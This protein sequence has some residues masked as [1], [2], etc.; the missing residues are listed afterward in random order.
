MFQSS[1]GLSTGCNAV[2]AVLLYLDH[3]V[4]ILTRSFD[5]M[6]RSYP[7]EWVQLRPTAVSILTRSF[8]RMQP[9]GNYAVTRLGYLPS[10]NPHP[11]FRPDA[12]G[13]LVQPGEY[14]P[15]AVSILIR[16]KDRVQH[17]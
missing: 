2:V 11:V 10:F 16:S 5:R 1:P 8:D 9:A 4:S 12:T 7:E 15:D 6:Q 17:H 3:G 14:Y 13:W